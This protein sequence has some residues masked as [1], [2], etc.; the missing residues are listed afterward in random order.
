MH[1]FSTR[2]FPLAMLLL[3]FWACRESTEKAEIHEVVIRLSEEPDRLHPMLSKTGVAAQL[4]TKLFL[5]LLNADPQNLELVPVLAKQLPEISKFDD[6][7]IRLKYEIKEEAKWDDGS[8]ITAEDVL[9]TVK[10]SFLPGLNNSSWRSYLNL[11]DSVVINPE[12]ESAFSYYLSE[13]YILAVPATGGIQLYPSHYYDPK[14]ILKNFS[15]DSLRAMDSVSAELRTLIDKFNSSTFSRDSI[16]GAGPYRLKKW[17]TGQY[18]SLEKKEDYWG[19]EYTG[20]IADLTAYPNRLQYMIVPDE[21]TAIAQLKSAS[22]DIAGN[23]SPVQFKT[24]KNDS[25]FAKDHLFLSP[26]IFRQYVIYLNTDD[27]LLKNVAL[28]KALAHL[29]D[30]KTF[31]EDALQGM[32]T[33]ATGPIHPSK[34]YFDPDVEIP[35]YN[36]D[37]AKAILDNAGWLDLDDDG[38]REKIIEGRKQHLEWT[39]LITGSALSKSIA[40]RL[41][42]N[43]GNAGVKVNIES[44]PFRNILQRM[45]SGDYQMTPNILSTSVF[46]DDLYQSWHTDNIGGGG[47]NFTRFGTEETDSIIEE[48]RTTLAFDK[49]KDLYIAFQKAFAQHL[50]AIFLAAPEES[51]IHTNNIDLPTSPVKPGY[52]ENMAQSAQDDAD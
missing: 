38:Y 29:I 6:G 36:I 14:G 50:P 28:R 48:I 4:E 2:I 32:G 40:L 17:E 7:S 39:I 33:K 10:A 5:P 27:P 47:Y 35:D 8:P 20:E 46:P 30:R 44:M 16:S 12:N 49:Q 21:A 37:K 26:E 22:L 25:S 13:S 31:I 11:V 51:I 45:R 42:E 3:S 23:I 9:F 43:A 34:P 41:Q 1:S 15:L 19:A 52:L 24:L 18:L